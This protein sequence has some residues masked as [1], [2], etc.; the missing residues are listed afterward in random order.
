MASNHV[1]IHTQQVFKLK[2]NLKLLSPYIFIGLINVSCLPLSIPDT[3]TLL[4]LTSAS[5]FK[6]VRV[7]PLYP[8]ILT[9]TSIDGSNHYKDKWQLYS[10]KVRKSFNMSPFLVWVL[11]FELHFNV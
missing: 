3:G 11:M 5:S 9:W 1:H 4:A 7:S 10:G 2:L 6:K 8:I